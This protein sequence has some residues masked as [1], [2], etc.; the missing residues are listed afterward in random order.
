MG[1][2]ERP[3]LVLRREPPRAPVPDPCPPPGAG[4]SVLILSGAI[5]TADVP[6]LC[7]RA[8]ALLERCDADLVVCDVEGLADPDALTIDTLARIQLIARRLGRRVRFRRACGELEQ[9]LALAGL[10]DVLP[11]GPSSGIEARGQP[12]EGKEPLRVEEEADPG[13]PAL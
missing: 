1:V 4:S 12:E 5:V 8:R 13:D 2:N 6:A 9:L 11:C 10:D 3:R 7:D